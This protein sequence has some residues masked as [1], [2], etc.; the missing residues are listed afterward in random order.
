MLRVR[1]LRVGIGALKIL[2]GVDLDIARGETVGLVGEGGS[3]KSM[4][5]LAIM[6]LLPDAA[7]AEGSVR[8]EDAEL[9]HADEPTLCRVRGAR[10]AMV[11]QEPATALD[12]RV[13]IGRQVAEAARAHGVAAPAA[14]ARALLAR[15]G[16]AGVSPGAYPHQMSGGQRQRAMIAGALVCEPPLL[17]ADEPTT[18]LDTITQAGVLE[19]LA[20]LAAERQMAMLLISHDLNVVARAT[21]RTAVMYAG[22]IVETATTPVRPRHPYTAALLA[23]S[24]VAAALPKP[25]PGAMPGPRDLPPGCAYAPRCPRADAACAVDPTLVDGV[26]C[27]H[28][29]W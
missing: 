14:R 16:L 12:P 5:A 24:S 15:V 4:L 6:G 22:R 1:D 17:L 2:R 8:F 11:F 3:G 27:H 29:F 7:H 21:A 28:P 10:I 20:E 9:L 19:L 13:P 25:I 18:A 26:A 23:A